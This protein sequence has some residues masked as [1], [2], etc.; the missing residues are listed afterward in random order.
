MADLETKELLLV[1]QQSADCAQLLQLDDVWT[2]M[3]VRGPSLGLSNLETMVSEIKPL[4]DRVSERAP[5]VHAIAEAH[6]EDLDEATRD[7]LS[8]G[9]L[10]ESDRTDLIWILRRRGRDS[11]IEVLRGASQALD[12]PKSEAQYLDEQLR[13]ITVGQFVTGDLSRKFRC[14]LSLSLIGGSILT[15]PSSAAAGF[16][17]MAVGGAAAG[18]TGMFLTGGVGGIALLVAGLFVARRSGC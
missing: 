16:G 2:S 1:I 9:Q 18:V 10:S 6:I 14:G 15:F 17:V 11:V 8:S 7:L 12:D 3:A 5:I 13:R 4:I